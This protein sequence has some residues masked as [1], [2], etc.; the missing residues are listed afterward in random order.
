MPRCEEAK[1]K[2]VQEVR[3]LANLQHPGIVRY[4]NAWWEVPPDGWQHATDKAYFMEERQIPLHM[5]SLP[6]GCWRPKVRFNYFVPNL[7]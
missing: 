7:G 4:F 3:A 5:L 2:I 6:I 1:K